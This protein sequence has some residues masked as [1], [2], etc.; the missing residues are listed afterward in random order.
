MKNIITKF[1]VACIVMVFLSACS[2]ELIHPKANATSR[3]VADDFMEALTSGDAS[4]VIG[5][6]AN[7]E[8]ME[9]YEKLEKETQVKEVYYAI[10]V[11]YRDFN[12]EFAG[13]RDDELRGE[14]GKTYYYN[15]YD[16]N[17]AISQFSIITYLTSKG[18]RVVDL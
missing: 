4:K 11:N 6:L 16:G 1:L 13:V 2:V 15:F 7:S 17:V 18:W 8:N 3:E 5:S 14:K 10:K 9:S 12:Y